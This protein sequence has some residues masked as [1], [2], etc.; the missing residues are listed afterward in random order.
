MDVHQMAKDR[1]L[2]LS[3][4]GQRGG[5]SAHRVQDYCIS[6]NGTIV[7]KTPRFGWHPATE[8]EKRAVR[9]YEKRRRDG[10]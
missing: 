10:A 8:R 7:V 3:A 2:S 6:D 4:M 1:D 9:W 5:R